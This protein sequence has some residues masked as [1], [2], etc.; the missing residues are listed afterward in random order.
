[1][2]GGGGGFGGGGF[3]KREPELED[4]ISKCRNLIKD[5]DKV[6]FV[7][8]AP[9]YSTRLDFVQGFG[10]VGCKSTSDFARKNLFDLILSGHIH[11]CA[12]RIDAIGKAK[13]YNLSLHIRMI[14]V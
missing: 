7:T 1:M 4:F 13:A 10:H 8:H 6:V 12:G 9:P 14:K 2:E 11:E 3:S 5:D